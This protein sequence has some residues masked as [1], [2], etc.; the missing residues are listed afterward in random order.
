MQR[1]FDIFT[2]P[3]VHVRAEDGRTKAEIQES[4]AGVGMDPADFDEYL[5]DALEKQTVMGVPDMPGRY[6]A[7]VFGFWANHFLH[8]N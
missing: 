8:P 1:T 4:L 3:L 7:T 2:T 6:C 5:S